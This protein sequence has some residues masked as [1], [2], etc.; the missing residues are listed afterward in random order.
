MKLDGIIVS[1]A[2]LKSDERYD[3]LRP[4]STLRGM[5]MAR[6]DKAINNLAGKS[7]YDV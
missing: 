2:A 5:F 7:A 3:I 6:R 4:T 1:W